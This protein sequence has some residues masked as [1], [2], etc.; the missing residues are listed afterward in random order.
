MF[1]S[2]KFT[3]TKS[4]PCL[5]TSPSFYP[6]E[7]LVTAPNP[8]TSFHTVCRLGL[9]WTSYFHLEIWAC[10]SARRCS[11]Q[12]SNSDIYRH[13]F[14]I[15]RLQS[16][17]VKVSDVAEVPLERSNC[18]LLSYLHL[19]ENEILMLG[20]ETHLLQRDHTL[21]VRNDL[22]QFLP[23]VFRLGKGRR[24]PIRLILVQLWELKVQ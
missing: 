3:P 19:I 22:K 23:I 13:K 16:W 17:Q 6:L 8:C 11:F 12:W 7:R 20:L 15:L 9:P 18:T 4:F 24:I 14:E 21:P 2:W 1:S 10:V 5:K